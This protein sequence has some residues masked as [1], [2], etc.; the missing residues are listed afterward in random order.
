M[1]MNFLLKNNISNFK[2]S[3]HPLKMSD[4]QFPS[5]RISQN[6]NMSILQFLPML[7]NFIEFHIVSWV[8]SNIV[9][10][11]HQLSQKIV[12]FNWWFQLS[13]Y[14]YFH[15]TIFFQYFVELV[16][17]C[18]IVFFFKL[19]TCFL[20]VFNCY[21]LLTL[22]LRQLL[23]LFSLFHLY[24]IFQGVS[25]IIYLNSL[26][27]VLDLVR[28]SVESMA[29]FLHSFGFWLDS[30]FLLISSLFLMSFSFFSHCCCK[31]INTKTSCI[32]IIIDGT[33]LLK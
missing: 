15:R 17:H 20:F 25:L 6:H 29:E 32:I 11:H 5:I 3:Q 28:F 23:S 22:L 7:I 1:M 26:L 9:K 4:Q 12:N 31:N 14:Q 16:K 18:L 2:H 21:W 27:L 24:L 19:F 33:K 30:L 8:V 13:C 10:Y